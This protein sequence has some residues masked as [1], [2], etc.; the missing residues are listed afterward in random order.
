MIWDQVKNKN[1][2]YGAP[3]VENG[4]VAHMEET[5]NCMSDCVL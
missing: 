3:N 2:Y 4:W 1:T 5:A